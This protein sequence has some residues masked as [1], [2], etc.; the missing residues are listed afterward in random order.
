MGTKV[1]VVLTAVLASRL[2]LRFRKYALAS[3]CSQLIRQCVSRLLRRPRTW[4]HNEKCSWKNWSERDYFPETLRK[5]SQPASWSRNTQS[6]P[7]IQLVM[8]ICHPTNETVCDIR[9]LYFSCIKDVA[10]YLLSG[11][12]KS[13]KKTEFLHVYPS[14]GT[15]LVTWNVARRKK[16]VCGVDFSRETLI[17]FEEQEMLKLRNLKN[18]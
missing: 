10:G 14:V 1:P 6:V 9:C 12:S 18:R 15:K 17:I 4:N 11:L 16:N 8:Y 5:R 3:A 7:L 13:K 2:V